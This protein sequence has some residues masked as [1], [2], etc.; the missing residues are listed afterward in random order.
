M[1]RQRLANMRGFTLIEVLI[2][3]VLLASVFVAVLGLSSQSLR[4]LNRMEPHQRALSH[5]RE[6]M[7]QLLLLEELQPGMT[8]GSWEDGYRWEAAVSPS[9]FND[10]STTA[11]YGL[12]DIRLVIH[13][14]VAPSDRT[15]VVETT[16]WAKKVTS[17]ANR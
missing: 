6:K 2:S 8:S 5:A 7:N 12:F 11:G 4:N 9:R 1:N 17:D 10:K 16:Q 13:W 14:G 3:T 15:Y